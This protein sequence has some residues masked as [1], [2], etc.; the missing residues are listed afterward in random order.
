MICSRTSVDCRSR[1]ETPLK[2]LI[3]L[4]GLLVVVAATVARDANKPM[5]TGLKNASVIAVG[6][7]GKVYLG[8][9]AEPDKKGSGSI[10]LVDGDKVTPL[11]TG[12]ERPAGIVTRGDMVFVADKGQVWRVNREGKAD[13]FASP[14]AFPTPPHALSGIDVDEKGTLYVSDAGN[15]KE[16]GGAVYRINGEGAAKLVTDSKRSEGLHSPRGIVMDGMSH[17]LVTDGVSGAL[18]RIKLADGT[19]TELAQGTGAGLSWDKHGRLYLADAKGGRVIAIPRPGE[20]AVAVAS[21]FQSAVALAVNSA[22]RKVLVLDPTA[23]T[24]TAVP[25]AIP[26]WEVDETP[27]PLETA[28]AFPDLQWTGWTPENDA[29]KVTPLRPVLLTHAGDGSNRVFVGTQHGVVHVFPNDQ[30][31]TKTKVFLDISQKVTYND[32]RNE[33]GFLGLTFHPDYKKNGEFFVF[34]TPKDQKLTNYVSRFHVSKSD[35]DRADPDSEE[36]LLRITNRLFWNHDGGTICFGPDGYFYIAVGDGGVANDPKRNGQNL[37]SLLAKVLRIDVDHKDPDKAYAVPKDNPFVETPE[38]RPEIWAYG[39]RNIWRMAFDRKTGRLWAS[40]VGQN[41]YEEIDFIV[42]GGNYGWN[43]REGLH[44]FGTPGV[45]P[46]KDLIEPIWEYNHDVGKSLTGG[47]VYRGE[48]LPELN[49][50]YLYADY[51]SAKIWALR[52]DDAKGR[53]VENRSIRDPNVPVMSFG[54]DEKSEAYFLT[55]SSTGK[56]IYRFVRQAEGK[57]KNE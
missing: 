9:A 23:G 54:E 25:A 57:A 1:K 42:R 46:R 27:L 43:L 32:N 39:L 24:L 5:L 16:E 26:G 51:V 2:K 13:V 38:A 29:G 3:C 50:Y 47:L 10:A 8:V 19:S 33:E 53:V 7:D 37:N 55:F 12:F 56:G 35:P 36:I 34:Y 4:A 49:G 31:A 20:A 17:V 15:D 28:V 11:A 21:G 44:P 48:L 14:D 52:Y 45:G 22:S 41:L 6:T 30:K 18:L 40:D